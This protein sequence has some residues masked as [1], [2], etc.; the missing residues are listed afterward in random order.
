MDAFDGHQSGSEP[1]LFKKYP[2]LPGRIPWLSLAPLNTPVQH[3][4]ALGERLGLKSLWI[5]RDDLT[6]PLYGGNKVRKL[7]FI[8][9]DARRRGCREVIAV[10]GTG[11]GA[12]TAIVL[13]P[14]YTRTFQKLEIR[15]IIGKPRKA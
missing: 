14:A 4:L 12:D 8:L 15:E 5:K 7:E 6:S 3:C 2:E 9:A 11:E 13:K 1:L 10:G